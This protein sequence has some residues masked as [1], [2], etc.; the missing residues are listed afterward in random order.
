MVWETPFQNRR[1]RVPG[2]GRRGGS[3]LRASLGGAPSRTEWRAE[4]GCPAARVPE[5]PH[6][7]ERLE[8]S[9]GFLHSIAEAGASR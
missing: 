6:A 5:L 9:D 4:D 7:S 8:H 2:A 3:P 1:K